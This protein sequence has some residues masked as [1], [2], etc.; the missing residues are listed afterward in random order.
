MIK[1]TK[2]SKDQEKA[3]PCEVMI[4]R[5]FYFQILKDIDTKFERDNE[6]RKQ[7]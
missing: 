7:V 2:L 4:V 6:H 3:F 1:L 5:N